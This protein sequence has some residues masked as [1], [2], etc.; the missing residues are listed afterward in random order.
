MRTLGVITGESSGVLVVDVDPKSGGDL[1][2]TDLIEA[3]GDE[4]LET[5]QVCTGSGGFHFFFEYPKGLDLRN[6]AGKIGPGID[7]RANGGY[8]VLPSSLHVS[9]K[10]Y[11]LIKDARPQPLPA[12]LLEILSSD[13]KPE[14]VIDFQ[15][16]ERHTARGGIIAE[17]Q[18]NDEL[19]RIGCGIWGHGNAHDT[20]DLCNQLLDVNA[21]RCVPPLGDSEVVKIAGSIARYPRGIPIDEDFVERDI[22]RRTGD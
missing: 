22:Q 12:W 5:R 13:K 8:V 7:T 16:R 2:L 1:T 10:Y 6:T 15:A 14:K 20:A 4:W 19:F 11:E 17:G 9:G 21:V 3:Y 18:R